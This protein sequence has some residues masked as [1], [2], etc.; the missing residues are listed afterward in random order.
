[1][2]YAPLPNHF[3]FHTLCFRISFSRLIFCYLFRICFVYKIRLTFICHCFIVHYYYY[4]ARFKCITNCS[5]TIHTWAWRLCECIRYGLHRWICRPSPPKCYVA[6]IVRNTYCDERWMWDA[7]DIY[8]NHRSKKCTQ[9]G[10]RSARM[11]T[12]RL[13]IQIKTE[14]KRTF[15]AIFLQR[16]NECMPTGSVP[17][18]SI[19]KRKWNAL[20]IKCFVCS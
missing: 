14:L 4:F 17:A 3:I 6:Y 1:M 5:H 8:L 2:L 7:I 9:N 16:K 19:R 10:Q 13:T 12:S 15:I 18:Y 20:M 11:T